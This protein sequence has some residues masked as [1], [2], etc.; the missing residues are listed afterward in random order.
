MLSPWNVTEK[1][2]GKQARFYIEYKKE[3]NVVHLTNMI[4][5]KKKY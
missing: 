1:I 5:I 2:N 4:A 3:R